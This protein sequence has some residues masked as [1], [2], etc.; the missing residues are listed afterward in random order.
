[1]PCQIFGPGSL[2]QACKTGN[3]HRFS[4]AIASREKRA[5]GAV[6]ARRDFL[7][8]PNEASRSGARLAPSPPCVTVD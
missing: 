5:H 3:S 6:F 7:L 8:L 4:F 2:F 1:M